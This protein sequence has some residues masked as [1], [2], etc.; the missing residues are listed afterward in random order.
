MLGPDHDICCRKL[1]PRD[2]ARYAAHLRRLGTADRRARFMGELAP[3]AIGRL[4]GRIDWGRSVL[5]G[6][7]IDGVL[8]ATAELHPGPDR[9]AEAALTVEPRFQH[10]GLGTEL[11]RRLAVIARNRAIRRLVLVCLAG[12]ARVR[13][14]A[15]KLGAAVTVLEDEATAVICL[16]PANP[17]TQMGELLDD[18]EALRRAALAAWRGAAARLGTGLPGAAAR[19]AAC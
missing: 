15:E 14:I 5:L 19:V 13:R 10:A 8:R 1:G 11:M 6:C 7:F 4:A 9:I 16:L 18:A 3:R 2:A 12:N 17:A